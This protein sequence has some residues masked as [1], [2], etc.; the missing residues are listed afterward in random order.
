MGPR[1]PRARP[2]SARLMLVN[3]PC[4][5]APSATSSRSQGPS[6]AGL[7]TAEPYIPGPGLLLCPG[8]R[9]A[10]PYRSLCISSNLCQEHS[11][12][13]SL[14]RPPPSRCHVSLS[15]A[16]ASSRRVLPGTVP[17][18][19]TQRPIPIASDIFS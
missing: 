11:P 12:P 3:S 14:Q 4:P 2:V 8:N 10:A 1:A 17:R 6:L 18:L 15:A 13:G 5:R 7:V 19:P 16:A 9:P